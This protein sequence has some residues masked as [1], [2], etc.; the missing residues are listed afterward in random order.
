MADTIIT[1]TPDRGA[2]DGGGMVI[3]TLLL[4]V[5]AVGGILLYRNGVFNAAP[6]TDSDDSTNINISVPN[7]VTDGTGEPA[8][9]NP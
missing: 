5:V 1:N 6:A 3:A 4:I 2:D 8:P 9:Q 7:P